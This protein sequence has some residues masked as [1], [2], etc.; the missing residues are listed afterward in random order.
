M[1]AQ[2]NKG[3]IAEWYDDWLM[4][5]TADKVFYSEFFH[6]LQGQVL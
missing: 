3:L 2:H 4:E 6:G 1:Q 5:V